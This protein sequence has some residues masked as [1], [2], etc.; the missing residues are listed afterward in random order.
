MKGVE[1]VVCVLFGCFFVCSIIFVG[2]LV[3]YYRHL[4]ISEH[5]LV[6]CFSGQVLVVVDGRVAVKAYWFSVQTS[7]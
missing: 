2:V 7:C 1:S 6:Q 3:F 5:W 4:D